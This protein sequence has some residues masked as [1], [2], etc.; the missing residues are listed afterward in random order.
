MNEQ[1]KNLWADSF[2]ERFKEITEGM[3]YRELSGILSISK[4]T[5]YAYAQGDRVPKVDALNTIAEKFNVNPMWLMGADVPKYGNADKNTPDTLVGIEGLP[6]DKKY[7]VSK[8]LSLSD[9]EVAGL[10]AIVE[11]VLAL[12]G[13]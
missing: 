10:R 9:T 6:E 4:S 5:A 11:Q 3:T 7:L 8:I 2:A 13:Q 1:K 12:R